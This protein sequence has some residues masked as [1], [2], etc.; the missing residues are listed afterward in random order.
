MAKRIAQTLYFA[1][2]IITT[3]FV[4]SLFLA[5]RGPEYL[6]SHSDLLNESVYNKISMLSIVNNNDNTIS[7]VKKEPLF[8]ESYQNEENNVLIS[9]IDVSFYG[10]IEHKKKNYFDAF[11]LV[12]DNIYLKDNYFELDEYK[13]PLI[14][15]EIT[16][17]ESI[18]QKG[19]AVLNG[20]DSW[21]YI[22]KLDSL[23]TNN[24]FAELKTIS[25][26]TV[27]NYEPHLKKTLVVLN[28][29]EYDSE[30]YE[31]EFDLSYNRDI[32]DVNIDNLSLSNLYDL[33]GLGSNDMF[34]Y[35]QALI[36]LFQRY[37]Y[38]LIYWLL[39]T[40]IILALFYYLLFY[41]KYVM[42]I[43]RVKN[44]EK[45]KQLL[46]LKEKYKDNK[47]EQNK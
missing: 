17:N 36:D 31:D 26:S 45:K 42:M 35:N 9:S 28:N 15:L 16:F 34:Y 40:F 5:Q 30:V 7:Y 44:E 12:I 6:K 8:F 43:I 24:G 18:K 32:K 22:F 38:H 23:K 27:Y 29:S 39:I 47:G 14:N 1:F 3:F 2:T 20:P 41:H 10:L 11:A 19:F 37:N 4:V 13:K 21:I 25:I 33:D 46:T